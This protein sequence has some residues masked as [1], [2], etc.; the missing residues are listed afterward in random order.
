[1]VT[2]GGACH[3]AWANAFRLSQSLAKVPGGV[4][5]H[6]PVFQACAS[7]GDHPDQSLSST[8]RRRSIVGGI[9]NA[10]PVRSRR[11]ASLTILVA[12]WTYVVPSIWSRLQF[13]SIFFAASVEIRY[14]DDL[15]DDAIRW[16]SSHIALSK[17]RQLV[18]GTR[19]SFMSL[20]PDEEE[21]EANLS[22][23]DQRHFDEDG[24][25]FWIKRMYLDKLHPIRFA[26][27]AGDVHFFMYKGCWVGLRRQPYKDVNSPWVASMEKLFFYAAPWRQGTLKEL[28]RE[29]QEMSAEHDLD[30]VN[31]YRGLKSAGSSF[32]WTRAA[33]KRPRPLSTIVLDP[34]QKEAIIDNIRNYLYPYTRN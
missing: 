9:A 25:D 8:G 23:E 32:H 33:S 24:R 30:R 10:G 11:A 5:R 4:V 28:L 2:S 21:E 14:H 26:P 15:Y 18:A 17:T 19:M 29:I 12:F 27:A 34:E 1:M 13:L 22:E 3:G 7:I 20:W 31:V 16:I 6:P